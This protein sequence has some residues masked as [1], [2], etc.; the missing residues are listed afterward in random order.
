MGRGATRRA[1]A[2][3][4]ASPPPPYLP[5]GVRY[6]PQRAEGVLPGSIACDFCKSMF[7]HIP[8]VV[9]IYVEGAYPLPAPGMISQK[10]GILP[11]NTAMEIA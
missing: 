6:P 2:L 4:A 7:T 9:S 11:V 3:G 5:L 10:T 8:I 1:E